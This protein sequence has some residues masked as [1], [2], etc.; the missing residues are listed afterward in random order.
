M[1]EMILGIVSDTHGRA[2]RLRVALG[3]LRERGATAFVH[4]GDLGGE[5]V[6]AELAAGATDE[7]GQPR[8]WFVWGNT[9]PRDPLLDAFAKNLGLPLPPR[10]LPLRLN[11]DGRRIVVCHGHERE[12]SRLVESLTALA[13]VKGATHGESRPDRAVEFDDLPDFVL[14]GHTHVPAAER[15][16]P[17]RLINPGALHR[18]AKYTVAALDLRSEELSYFEVP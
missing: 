10:T 5:A 7:T 6:I 3:T 14:Y 17:A 15:C 4:C 11:L 16:G 9:D 12:F 2:E 18:A 8:V 13:N 1:P